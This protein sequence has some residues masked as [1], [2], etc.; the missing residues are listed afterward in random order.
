M[1]GGSITSGL[2]LGAY[3]LLHLCGLLIFFTL[4]KHIKPMLQLFYGQ[5]TQRLVM[6]FAASG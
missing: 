3:H 6:V 1:L 4:H 5:V 2:L